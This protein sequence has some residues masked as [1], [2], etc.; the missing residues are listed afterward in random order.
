[1][2]EIV[3]RIT[4]AAIYLI[5]GFVVARFLSAM[6][7]RK[8][9]TTAEENTASTLSAR[10]TRT[11]RGL[12]AHLT[13]I[14]VYSITALLILALF[15]DSSGLWTFLGL[16]SAAFGLGARPLVS[17]Y[18]SGIIFLFEDQYTVGEK[19]EIFGVEGTVLSVNLRTT[20]LRAP[21]GELYII[22]NGEVRTVRNFGRGEF[23][24]ASIRVNVSAEQ[25]GHAI[26]VLE[27]LAP[28]LP[29]QIPQL[30][31]APKVL[32]EQ[33]T[34]GDRV[35]LTI[36]A[37]AKYSHG[38]EARSELLPAVHEALAKAGISTK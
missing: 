11:L 24:L 5:L 34:L 29:A 13:T 20:I 10:R 8:A 9:V 36:F 37:K 26:D 3:V 32:S 6:V 23:S 35:E 17:D 15:V 4:F 31:E 30:V 19:V 22:P 2:S 12:A 1:M 38:I 25:M 16:F 7:G 27:A 33:G 28:T 21:S 14:V 18:I